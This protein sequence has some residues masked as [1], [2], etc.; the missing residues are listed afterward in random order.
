M[1]TTLTALTAGDYRQ[2]AS[3]YFSI[4]FGDN[5]ELAFEPLL[6][7]NFYVALYQGQCLLAEKVAVRPVIG[8][9]HE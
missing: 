9:I 6:H 5:Y 7:G 3:G 1:K 2:R 4:E 8:E